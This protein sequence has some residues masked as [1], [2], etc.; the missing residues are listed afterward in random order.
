MYINGILLGVLGTLSAELA[1]V[2][3]AVIICGFC[4]SNNDRPRNP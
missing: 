3:L 4:A 1:L 2:F